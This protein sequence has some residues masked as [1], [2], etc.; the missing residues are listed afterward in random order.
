[1]SFDKAKLLAYALG[2]LDKS[3]AQRVEAFLQTNEEAARFV[4]EN[5]LFAQKAQADLNKEKIPAGL[6]LAGLE[7]AAERAKNKKTPR[8]QNKIGWLEASAGLLIVLAAILYWRKPLEGIWQK[9]A[10]HTDANLDFYQPTYSSLSGKGGNEAG[11]TLSAVQVKDSLVEW[12]NRPKAE[13]TF[14]ECT[15]SLPESTQVEAGL[16]KIAPE[17]KAWFYLLNEGQTQVRLIMDAS[18]CD[19]ALGIQANLTPEAQAEVEETLQ[20]LESEMN[21]RVKDGR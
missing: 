20:S 6:G 13:E 10:L 4:S 12:S 21:S 1:M 19:L 15:F 9:P 2:E 17:Q 14:G 16:T 5:R 18:S 7:R 3:E 8:T 11:K